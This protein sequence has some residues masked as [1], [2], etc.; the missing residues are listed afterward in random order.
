MTARPDHDE[1][2]IRGALRERIDGTPDAPAAGDWWERLY[3]EAQPDH[4][5]AASKRRRIPPLRRP[6]PRKPTT[7]PEADP[8]D[9]EEGDGWEDAEPDDESTPQAVRRGRRSPSRL[10]QAEFAG[11]ER[12]M[13]WLIST[14]AGAGIGWAIGLEHLLHGWITDCAHDTTPTSGLI[15][16]LGLVAASAGAAYRARGWWPPLAW[17]CRI[18]AATAL[19]ALCL[20]APGVAP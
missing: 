6:E 15:L 19:L 9:E 11:L 4:A 2:R 7:E 3:D 18:P 5:G 14:A 12:R 1:L 20:Y 16:G 17:A 8:A 10:V 13:Q